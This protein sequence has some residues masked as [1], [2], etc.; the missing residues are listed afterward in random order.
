MRD[1]RAPGRV[2]ATVPR[3]AIAACY[4]TRAEHRTL[5]GLKHLL[6]IYH[7]QSGKTASMAHAVRR[8]AMHPGIESVEVRMRLA[9]DAGPGDL[10]WCDAVIFA[11]PENFGYMAGAMKDFFDRTFYP[12][13]G[14]LEGTPCAVVVGAGNDGTGALAALRRIVRGFPLKEDAGTDR[15]QRTARRACS[16]P[17]RNARSDHC[18]RTR[19]RH[20]LNR[21]DRGRPRVSFAFR[22]RRRM[23]MNRLREFARM[24]GTLRLL[25][26]VGVV[27]LIIAA[28]F[29]DVPAYS[30]GWPLVRGVIAPT[31]FVIMVFVVPLD[32]TMTLVFMS[33]RQGAERRRLR[34]VAQTEA[35]LLV[36]MLV[37]WTPLVMRLLRTLD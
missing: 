18:G 33:D 11:T 20:V 22:S 3:D 31:L 7:S 26:A 25:L 12:C 5:R 10:F 28:P 16:L 17:L 24:F 6:I 21:V 14:R 27:A 23:A 2:H 13:Q 15:L 19:N 8:G 9:A 30:T 1:A 4:S 34:L 29:S 37:A 32:I 35:V 36:A